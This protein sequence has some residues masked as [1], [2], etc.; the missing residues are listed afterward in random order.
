MDQATNSSSEELFVLSDESGQ[1]MSFHFL[2]LILYEDREYLV[3]LPAEGPYQDE[4]VI[5]LREREED[6]GES[7]ADVEDP[8]TLRA[9]YEQF[10]SRSGDRFIFTD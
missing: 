2:D 10:R 1:E 6:G 9:V 3:L 7:Y 5:L 8:G 4:V